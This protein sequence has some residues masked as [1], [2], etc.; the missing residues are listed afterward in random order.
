[1]PDGDLKLVAA[2]SNFKP[3]GDGV[4]LHRAEVVTASSHEAGNG[5]YMQHNV[6][7]SDSLSLPH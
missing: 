3:F 5:K 6:V 7:L 2:K 4:V 1:L